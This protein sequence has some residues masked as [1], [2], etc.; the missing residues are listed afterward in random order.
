MLLP[1]RKDRSSLR[2]FADQWSSIISMQ[3]SNGKMLSRSKQVCLTPKTDLM[4]S[5]YNYFCQYFFTFL[6]YMN[7]YTHDR[8][9][10]AESLLVGDDSNTIFDNTSSAAIEKVST[11]FGDAS[12]FALQVSFDTVK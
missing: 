12:P 8:L 2:S 9:A 10:E 3:I 1:S 11:D 6:L 5:N 7:Y 4:H